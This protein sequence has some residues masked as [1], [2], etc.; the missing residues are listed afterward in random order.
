ME[1]KLAKEEALRKE[2]EDSNTKILTEKNEL[3]M[4][5]EAERTNTSEG[6]G[7]LQKLTSQK[8]DLEKQLNV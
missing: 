3:F 8:T 1:E 5:L 4:Q 7:R 2:L 6:E